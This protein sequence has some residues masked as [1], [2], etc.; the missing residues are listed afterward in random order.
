MEWRL[1]RVFGKL[2]ATSRTEPAEKLPAR[3]RQGPPQSIE[4]HAPDPLGQRGIGREGLGGVL[5]AGVNVQ[6]RGHPGSH[7]TLCERDVLVAEQVDR[8]DVDERRWQAGQVG[9]DE[10]SDLSA[11]EDDQAGFARFHRN[12]S[13]LRHAGAQR[14]ALTYGGRHPG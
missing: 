7:Q 13:E 5:A 4:P 6:L 10:T 9:G 1:G 12:G 2:G 14:S 8:A 3:S 11:A